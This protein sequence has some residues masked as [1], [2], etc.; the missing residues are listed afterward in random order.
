[1]SIKKIPNCFKKIQKIHPQELN[2]TNNSF[3]KILDDHS[4]ELIKLYGKNKD[5]K[6]VIHKFHKEKR[7]NFVYTRLSYNGMKYQTPFVKA[8]MNTTQK[9]EEKNKIKIE[10]RKFKGLYKLSDLELINLKN[11]RFER[12]KKLKLK[13]LSIKNETTNSHKNLFKSFSN[14]NE[15]NISKSSNMNMNKNFSLNDTNYSLNN[16]FRK[17][18]LSFKNSNKGQNSKESSTYYKSDINLKNTS[19]PNLNFYSPKINKPKYILDKCFEEIDSGNEVT[20]NMNKLDET[21]TK[22]IKSR[23]K[24]LGLMKKNQILNLNFIGIKKYKTLE[25]NNFNEIKRKMNEKISDVFAF[26]NRKGYNDL[27]KNAKSTNA[28][29]IYLHDMEKANEKLEKQRNAQRKKIKRLEMLCEDDFKKKEYLKKKINIY[30]KR[31]RNERKKENTS[32]DDEAFI[33]NKKINDVKDNE[34]NQGKFMSMLL[35]L[36][37]QCLKEITVGNFLI[38][39]KPRRKSIR[40]SYF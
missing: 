6:E 17:I 16:N 5:F 30:N 28:Y 29:D 27:I 1:M 11:K 15:N 33:T 8:L 10:K 25:R 24:E 31:H 37:E 34:L 26:K 14:F 39:K 4:D 22:S 12:F 19:L 20:K 35:S 2:N 18:N 13:E 21:Y 3:H 36:K 38:N 32:F 7:G 23:L 9:S 40:F